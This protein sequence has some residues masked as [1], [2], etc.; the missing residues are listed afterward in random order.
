MNTKQTRIAVWCVIIVLAFTSAFLSGCAPLAA[1]QLIK[2]KP[3]EDVALEKAVI[4]C[5]KFGHL[6]NT[7]EFTKC[8]EERYDEY[9]LNN[10]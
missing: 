5:E 6:P 8:A 7:S 3:I 9:L 10:R 4:M 2:P 1:S